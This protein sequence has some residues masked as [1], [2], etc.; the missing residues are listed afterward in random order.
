[1]VGYHLLWWSV[2]TK[3]TKSSA[4]LSGIDIF[5]GIFV[6]Q[7]GSVETLR[8][9]LSLELPFRV[10]ISGWY[11]LILENC[12]LNRRRSQST[13][14]WYLVILK[15]VSA[16]D[17]SFQ[18]AVCLYCICIIFELALKLHCLCMVFLQ[19]ICIGCA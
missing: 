14:G 6:Q 10:L 19:C 13:C 4:A 12:L 1:M 8:S 9:K 3:V 15:I 7:V 5:I 18:C 11:L 16:S 2:A 17:R